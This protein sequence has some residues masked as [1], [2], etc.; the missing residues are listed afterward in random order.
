ML[1]ERRIVSIEIHMDLKQRLGKLRQQSGAAGGQETCAGVAERVQRYRPGK[2]SS[3]DQSAAERQ[4]AA[5][6][7]GE[8]VDEGVLLI[9]RELSL[10]ASHGRIGLATVLDGHEALPEARALPLRNAVFLDTETSGLAGGTGTV[11]FLLGLARVENH[12]LV[13]RQYHLTRFSAEARLYSLASDW[14]GNADAVVTFNGKSFDGPLLAARH[15]LC[16]LHDPVARLAHLDL[17]HPTRR[18][19]S[20]RWGDCRLVTAERKLLGFEREDDM[21]GSMAPLAWFAWLQRNDPTGLIGI[22]RHNY[23][24]VLSLT[25][26]VPV[27]AAAHGDPGAWDADVTAIAR[28]YLAHDQPQRALSLLEEHR[29]MLDAA[30]SLV[31]ARMYRQ[32]K[33]WLEARV[34][35]DELADQGNQEA[36]ESLA[37]YYEHVLGDPARALD[38]AGRLALLPEHEHR[39]QRLRRKLAASQQG[40]C[41]LIA[42]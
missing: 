36:I 26:L 14:L 19:F 32:N 13:V 6:L 25:A 5:Q 30:G 38:Y 7:G 4:L 40:S 21:P 1:L 12:R 2:R 9:E 23:W 22:A 34:I 11:V 41:T 39:R 29:S 17:L 35:W 24:D 42:S 33:Q 37:K 15:R 10:S 8:V 31:L 28:A 20:N 27:L 16:A 18:A 3:G